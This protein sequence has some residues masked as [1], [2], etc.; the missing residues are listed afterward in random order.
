MKQYFAPELTDRV[1]SVLWCIGSEQRALLTGVVLLGRLPVHITDL[2]DFYEVWS[3]ERDTRNIR[4]HLVDCLQPLGI[5]DA[6][7]DTDN[8]FLTHF[9]ERYAKP[10]AGAA[11]YFTATTGISLSEI[12]PR[13]V[14][15]RR[16]VPL[17]RNTAETF[18][19]LMTGEKHLDEL[20]CV[21]EM[22][23][24]YTTVIRK[25][26]DCDLKRLSRARLVSYEDE[27]ARLTSRG[28]KVIPF[29]YQLKDALADGT[30]LISLSIKARDLTVQITRKAMHVYRE[31]SPYQ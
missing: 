15:S 18:L 2:A 13:Y 23:N 24:P 22:R 21:M 4:R 26:L 31:K 1:N 29:I 12:F 17:A 27:I 10:A 25:S 5:A 9:G 19:Q 16:R 11:L 20:V 7:K 30:M 3:G 14:R 6:Q 28:R 8:Y